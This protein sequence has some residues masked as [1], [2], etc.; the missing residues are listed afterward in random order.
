MCSMQKSS[1]ECVMLFVRQHK[2]K[3]VG[4]FVENLAFELLFA[5]R[6]FG[7]R[8]TKSMAGQCPVCRQVLTG[9]AGVLDHWF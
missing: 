8:E 3:G 1:R 9:A 4:G 7:P 6:L 5:R 2:Q